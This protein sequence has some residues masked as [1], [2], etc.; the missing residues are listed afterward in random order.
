MVLTY[1]YAG[2]LTAMFTKPKLQSPITSLNELLDQNAVPWVLEAGS[3][4]ETLMSTAPPN[5]T[6][7]KI[8]ERSKRMSLIVS[9]SGCYS[10]DLEKSG[11]FGAICAL[12]D[13]K[14]LSNK[15]FS[16][17]GNIINAMK[18]KLVKEKVYCSGLEVLKDG[19]GTKTLVL[20][21]QQ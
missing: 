19:L 4:L 6:T 15:V 8:Q 14:T 12:E 13:F 9:S 7:K 10:D 5:S 11:E 2:N 17:T 16:K 3:F 1:S 18:T 21:H 20:K